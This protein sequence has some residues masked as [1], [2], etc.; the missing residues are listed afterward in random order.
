MTLESMVLP[1]AVGSSMIFRTM[2]CPSVLAL[3]N[4]HM[5]AEDHLYDPGFQFTKDITFH[6]RTTTLSLP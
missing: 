2:T 5:H 4:T 3:Q 1:S 6:Q